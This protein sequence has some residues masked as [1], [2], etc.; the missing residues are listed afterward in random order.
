MTTRQ[1]GTADPARPMVRLLQSPI[2]HLL[3][4]TLVLLRYVSAT[5]ATII[6]PVQA[7]Q[8]AR[9]LVVFVGQADKKRWWRHFR[10]A[11]AA[12][13]WLDGSWH[14]AIGE[15][16]PTNGEAASLY[17]R[18]FPRVAVPMAAI[19]VELRCEARLPLHLCGRPLFLRWV[20]TVTAGEFAGFAFPAV[21]GALTARAPGPAAI[22][23]I[24]AAGAVE[25]TMLG[26]AQAAVLRRALPQIA[27]RRWVSATAAGAVLAYG[28]GML[29]STLAG[30][31]ADLP[32]AV[33][34]I[35][36]LILGSALLASIGTAQWLVLRTVLPRSASWIVSTA[37]AWLAGLGVFLGF[38]MPLWRPG[39]SVALI[40]AIGVVGGLLMAAVTSAITGLAVRRLLR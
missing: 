35:V 12:D 25:G 29:P 36:G 1:I 27:M 31:W 2:R 21:T 5:G 34:V 24:L 10:D 8:D 19:L 38:A 4:R 30:Q 23:A 3:P 17:R 14:P 22:V 15:V 37:A 7:A 16:S 18:R 33:L 6:L 39:Q 26:L 13:V 32:A 9:R 28:I 40:V 20:A 11:A